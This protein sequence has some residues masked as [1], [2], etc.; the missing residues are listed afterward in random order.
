MIASILATFDIQKATDDQGEEIT[1]DID[2][3]GGLI[4]HPLPIRCSIK[5]RTGSEFIDADTS[6][7]RL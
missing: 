1:P 7:N 4:S 3:T 2:Y 5:Q 6:E